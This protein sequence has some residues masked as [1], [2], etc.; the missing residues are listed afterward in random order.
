MANT[1]CGVQ[2]FPGFGIHGR[3]KRRV[4]RVA[5]EAAAHLQKLC[6]GDVLAV[7]HIRNVG[8][9]RIAELQL[10]VLGEQHDQRRQ[11]WSW[12]SRRCGSECS[13]RVVSA[14][15]V[16]WCRPPALKL[17]CGVRSSTIAPGTFSCLAA[18]ST[19]A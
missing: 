9:H 15:R 8:G 4:G 6:D 5:V 11:S 10:A 3:R 2:A 13:P 7:G 17:P 19:T 1:S 14:R 18:A 16:R 12:C